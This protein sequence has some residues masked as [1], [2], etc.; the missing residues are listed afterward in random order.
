MQFMKLVRDMMYKK[1]TMSCF[2]SDECRPILCFVH[3]ILQHS[4]HLSSSVFVNRVI[5]H[6]KNG[7]IEIKIYKSKLIYLFEEMQN[8]NPIGLSFVY[9]PRH[10]HPHHMHMCLVNFIYLKKSKNILKR[11]TCQ[12]TIN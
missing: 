8:Q 3:S 2:I 6:T 5:L 11:D 9:G 1:A 10:I 12:T 4:F 7:T